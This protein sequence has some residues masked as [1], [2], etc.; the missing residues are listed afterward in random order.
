M[1]ATNQQVQ[2]YVNE[3]VRVRAEQ[4]RSLVLAMEDD[5]AAIDD[6]YANLTDSPDWTDERTDGPPYL[7][8]PSDVLA[9]NAFITDSIAALK[10][11]ASYAVVMQGCVRPVQA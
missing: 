10:N 5:K 1:A 7:L 3:R 2:Q 6:V 9:F 4:I 8:T 11:H